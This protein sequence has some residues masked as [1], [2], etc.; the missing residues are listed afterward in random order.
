[1]ADSNETSFYEGLTQTRVRSQAPRAKVLGQMKQLVASPHFKF[2][3]MNQASAEVDPGLIPTTD[4]NDETASRE[5][6]RSVPVKT[7]ES[8]ELKSPGNFMRV[9]AA[10]AQAPPTHLPK[11]SLEQFVGWSEC[12]IGTWDKVEEPVVEPKI[13]IKEAYG[14]KLTSSIET[15]NE[16]GETKKVTSQWALEA[17]AY[18]NLSQFDHSLGFDAA[19]MRVDHAHPHVKPQNAP[20]ATSE[21]PA[22]MDEAVPVTDLLKMAFPESSFEMRSRIDAG[23]TTILPEAKPLVRETVPAAE[24]ELPEA[25]PETYVSRF[26]MIREIGERAWPEMTDKLLGPGRPMLEKLGAAIRQTNNAQTCETIVAGATRGCGA[27]TVA[28]ALA[29]WFADQGDRVLLVD[30]DVHGAG[31]TQTLKLT[32]HRSWVTVARGTNLS[33]KLFVRAAGSSIAFACLAP[34]R[35]RTI[36]Q[37]FIF[38]H[39]SKLLGTVEGVFD[40]ILIDVGSTNQLMAELSGN[41]TLATSALVVAT[42]GSLDDDSAIRCKTNLV[43][44]GIEHVLFAQNFAR[45]S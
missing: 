12:S 29:R 30:A 9:D 2:A 38:D 17:E 3:Q 28:M 18:Q 15:T 23:Q 33:K 22:G 19:R 25:A 1:M 8:P 41:C 4:V 24:P 20:T 36:W 31:I 14:Q 16:R 45:R 37:P 39:L 27:T 35:L 10:H 26:A 21:I 11:K 43:G 44:L 13:E 6:T 32:D 5:Q 34:L 40:R 7:H 42:V